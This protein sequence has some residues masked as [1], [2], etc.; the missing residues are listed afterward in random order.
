MMGSG[1]LKEMLMSIMKS[2]ILFMSLSVL[3]LA[4]VEA[5]YDPAEGGQM[6]VATSAGQ[7]SR[8]PERPG[9]SGETSASDSNYPSNP[10]AIED[11]AQPTQPNQSDESQ[12]PIFPEEL[13]EPE[14]TGTQSCEQI[15]AC[16][17]AQCS[18]NDRNCQDQC[19]SFGTSIA[20]QEMNDFL[21]CYHA[22]GCATAN[23]PNCSVQ[24][25]E[26]EIL[27]CLPDFYASRMPSPPNTCLGIWECL[28]NCDSSSCDERC[29]DAGGVQ[30][31]NAFRN[32]S[33]CMLNN[34]CDDSACVERFCS[35]EYAACEAN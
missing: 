25:C 21:N 3:C 33:N 6:G 30:A 7:N 20:Q 34:N 5:S 11:P 4:C 8:Y 2:V 19:V 1:T 32:I 12:D 31:Q 29:L 23:D 35:Q 9:S 22:A 15:M 16:L 27:Q 26:D 17:E 14:M 28:G 24:F 13:A 10:P 18:G